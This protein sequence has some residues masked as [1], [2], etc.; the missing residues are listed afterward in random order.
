MKFVNPAHWPRPSGYSN[1]VIES[2]FLF[3][4][5]QVGWD[6]TGAFSS[7]LVAQIRQTLQNICSVIEAAGGAPQQIVRLT[8]YVT[9]R[10]A[11]KARLAEIGAAYREIIGRHFPAMAVVEVSGLIEDAALVEIEATVAM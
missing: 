9:D 4:S 2:G 8:W 11:Y 10:Q 5:G 7:D 6:E 1:G 3:V